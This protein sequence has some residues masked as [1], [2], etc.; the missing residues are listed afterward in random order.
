MT[1]KNMINKEFVVIQAPSWLFFSTQ[2]KDIDEHFCCG[3]GKIYINL[4]CYREAL[5][6]FAVWH[7]NHHAHPFLELIWTSENLKYLGDLLSPLKTLFLFF[8]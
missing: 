1:A 2:G 6:T 8:F 7:N 3:G 5:S 4:P